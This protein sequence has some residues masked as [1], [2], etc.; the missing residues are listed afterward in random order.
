MG[1]AKCLQGPAK[2]TEDQTAGFEHIAFDNYSEFRDAIL[3]GQFTD[4]EVGLKEIHRRRSFAR[5]GP[6]ERAISTIH[7]A[8]GLQCK[9][10]IVLPCDGRRFDD[11]NYARC[12][13]YVANSR[14][15]SSL[16][17]VLSRRD[18]S[19]LFVLPLEIDSKTR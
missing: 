15:R 8:K 12:K 9:N 18:P 5:P 17:L 4:V 10:A 16:T 7:K 1:V 2:L 6:P 11:T 14:A 19:P 13:L 3:L